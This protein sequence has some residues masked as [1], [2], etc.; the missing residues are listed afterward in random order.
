MFRIVI[1]LWLACV[2]VTATAAEKRV[3]LVIGNGSY[4]SVPRLDNAG[5]DAAAVAKALRDAGFDSVQVERDLGRDAMLAA[6]RKFE[7][8][9]DQADWALVY[10]AGHGMEVGGS[11][12]LIP[13]DARLRSDRDVE[14]EAISLGQVQKRIESARKLRLVILDA[15]RENP[16]AVQMQKT[17]ASRTVGRGLARPDLP[18]TGSLVAFAAGTGQIALDGDARANSPYATALIKNLAVPDVEVNLFF[19]RVRAD[20]LSATD[21]KQEPA[22]YESLPAERYVFRPAPVI[23]PTVSVVPPANLNSPLAAPIV[24]PTDGALLDMIR[25]VTDRVL[26]S[27]LSESPLASVRE[28]AVA[29]LATL[30][31]EKPAKPV[32]VARPAQ[33]AALPPPSLMTAPED[34]P[35]TRSFIAGYA[36]VEFIVFSKDGK[37]LFSGFTRSLDVIERQSLPR[38]C[39]VGH[40]RA[41][42]V[43]A[44]QRVSGVHA[45]GGFVFRRHA[46]GHR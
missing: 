40:Q 22:T 5:R 11:N 15:C 42:V 27:R 1:A 30:A 44:G 12:Y 16:F 2:A 36:S 13:I 43:S 19:R 6:L 24:P 10:F 39:E 32:E 26:L 33:L 8:Q 28:A 34:R 7:A 29:R 9:V 45:R 25:G 4:A 31:P 3:A 37:T 46:S 14:D 20:V 23:A 18:Q 17:L 38:T 41:A 35:A 21:Q